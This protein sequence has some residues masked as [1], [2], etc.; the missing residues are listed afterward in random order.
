MPFSSNE[1]PCKQEKFVLTGAPDQLKCVV[2]LSGDSISHAVSIIKFI[3][4]TSAR[5]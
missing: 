5:K 2:S 1:G 3:V 4:K